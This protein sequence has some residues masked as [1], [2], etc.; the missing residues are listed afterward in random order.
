MAFIATA[1]VSKTEIVDENP[2]DGELPEML[3][4][5]KYITRFARL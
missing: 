4:C 5:K 3:T 1:V 2:S